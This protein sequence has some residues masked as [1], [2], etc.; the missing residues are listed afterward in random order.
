MISMQKIAK[1][2]W[3]LFFSFTLLLLTSILPSN[4]AYPLTT[5]NV[6]VEKASFWLQSQQQYDGGFELAGSPGFETPDAIAAIASSVQNGNTYDSS[7]AFSAIQSLVKSSKSPLDYVDDLVDSTFT[8]GTACKL[9]VNVAGPLG[10]DPRD[11]DPSSDSDLPIDLVSKIETSALS[12]GSFGSGVLNTTLTCAI[13][14]F[15]ASGKISD[16][17]IQYIENSQSDDG[18]FNYAGDP[19]LADGGADT[20]GLAIETLVAGGKNRSDVS[21]D[22]ALRYLANTLRDDGSYLSFGVPDPNSTAIGLLGLVSAGVDVTNRN[23]RDFYAPNRKSEKYVSPFDWLSSQQSQ[24]GNF[25]SPYDSYG[26]NTF[27]TSQVTSALA[28][29]W[30]PIRSLDPLVISSEESNETT[31]SPTIRVLGETVSSTGLASKR[32]RGELAR[33]GSD[34]RDMT[35]VAAVILLLGIGAV[36]FS[37][38]AK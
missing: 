6:Q 34:A 10:L 21:I 8:S 4:V 36:L 24:E 5:N 14:L 29:S 16:Q 13:A 19:S 35:I 27:A 25:A 17:T 18:S 9:I 31:A 15:I 12:D 23:W 30:F 33:T 22:K 1:L 2:H 20:T 38:K 3:P 11:F 32:V 7:A 37:R 28:Q 26:L